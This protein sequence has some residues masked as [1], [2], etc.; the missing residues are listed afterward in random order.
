MFSSSVLQEIFEWTKFQEPDLRRMQMAKWKD[1]PPQK[2]PEVFPCFYNF[3]DADGNR[4]LAGLKPLEDEFPKVPLETS[5]EQI[6]VRECGWQVENPVLCWSAFYC[7][8]ADW[9]FTSEIVWWFQ[10][11]VADVFSIHFQTEM[12]RAMISISRVWLGLTAKS[13]T[14]ELLEAVVGIS[15]MFLYCF[16]ATLFCMLR[17]GLYQELLS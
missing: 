8:T 14:P 10:F 15:W 1:W 5:L 9:V 7:G 3:I 2:R 17:T 13:T 16:Y 11:R 6:T 12:P 4:I